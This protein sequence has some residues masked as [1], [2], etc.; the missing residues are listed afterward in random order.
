MQPGRGK[1]ARLGTHSNHEGGLNHEQPRGESPRNNAATIT[2]SRVPRGT[3][4]H[5]PGVFGGER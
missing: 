2:S 5:R 3:K 1:P 4:P